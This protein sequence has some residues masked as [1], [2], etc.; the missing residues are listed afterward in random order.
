MTSNDQGHGGGP[1]RQSQQPGDFGTSIDARL[2]RF[3]SKLPSSNPGNDQAYSEVE[4]Q[5]ICN[6]LR[7]VNNTWSSVP[8]IYIVLRLIGQVPL[9]DTFLNDGLADVS[10]P[11]SMAT[12][13]NVLSPSVKAEFINA[14]ALV[15]TNMLDLE[16]GENGKHLFF[17]EG[18]EPPYETLGILGSGGYGQ[19]DKVWSKLSHKEFARK[20]I[21]RIKRMKEMVKSY[22]NEARILKSVKHHHIVE[23]VMS[24]VADCNLAEFFLLAHGST[25][26]KSLLRSYFGCLARALEYLHNKRVRHKDIKP[27]NILV[28]Q[29]RVL[30]TDFGISLD[31]SD[32]AQSTTTGE[33]VKSPKY[34]APEVSASEPWNSSSDIWSL[35]CVFLEMIS[36]LKGETID[37]MK[38]FF[39]AHGST[40]PLYRLNPEATSLWMASLTSKKGPEYEN[41][42]LSMISNM[43]QPNQKIRP[44]AST[45]AEMFTFG[46]PGVTFCGICCQVVGNPTDDLSESTDLDSDGEDKYKGWKTGSRLG[47]DELLREK[48]P[49]KILGVP[50]DATREVIRSAHR[51]LI[52]QSHPD[53]VRDESHRT[54]Q[55]DEFQLVQEASDR[56][57]TTT[58]IR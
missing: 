27:Q 26:K 46:E 30:F 32:L 7:Q 11:F 34:C 35:G 44:T 48:D 25:D 42:P 39:E 20:R 53:R 19:V 55:Q 37:T 31:W 57:R 24:P 4:I 18:E 49:Y 52:R 22:E 29:D 12:L 43:L 8:R 51:K 2:A 23:L 17:K 54:H 3:F 10:L 15:M 6:H 47:D 58:A 14:Q 33:T 13:P 40:S 21:R 1:Q 56:R 36:V 16:K 45:V 5:Q 41:R 38:T 50:R 9:L 28:R